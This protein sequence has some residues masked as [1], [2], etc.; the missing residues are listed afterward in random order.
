[1]T[2]PAQDEEQQGGA[3][4]FNVS[5]DGRL[6]SRVDKAA[7]EEGASRSAQV[8]DLACRGLAAMLRDNATDNAAV[9]VR[10]PDASALP[11]TPELVE[12]DA[13]PACAKSLCDEAG[14]LGAVPEGVRSSMASEIVAAAS[15]LGTSELPMETVTSVASVLATDPACP[16]MVS[17]RTRKQAVARAARDVEELSGDED[18]SVPELASASARRLLY[19]ACDVVG[20]E[21]D[22]PV[23]VLAAVLGAADGDG[24]LLASARSWLQRILGTT[25]GEMAKLAEAAETLASGDADDAETDAATRL[26][27]R[28]AQALDGEVPRRAKNAP[29]SP[30]RRAA[31]KPRGAEEIVALATDRPRATLPELEAAAGISHSTLQRR[32]AELE[33]AGIM[34]NEGTTR[35]PLWVVAGT[36]HDPEDLLTDVQRKV[37]DIVRQDPLKLRTD[38]AAELG[39]SPSLVS[40]A[41]HELAYLGLVKKSG[42]GW[43]ATD[44]KD[45][46]R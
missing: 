29:S 27:V 7:K 37:L 9:I 11:L 32:L 20:V 23:Q 21:P 2:E 24:E 25:D 5:M 39:V 28:W 26:L 6:A 42:R 43:V 33:S 35:Q 34:R 38:V 3:E 10:L 36:E 46:T 1:M 18:A 17:S 31:F 22:G 30:R 12:R 41:Y 4:R 40:K 13:L 15:G 19:P 16:W 45:G 44:H 14:W 8:R